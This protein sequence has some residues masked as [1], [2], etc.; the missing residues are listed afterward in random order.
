MTHEEMNKECSRCWTEKPLTEFTPQPSGKYGRHSYCRECMR[1][2]RNRWNQTEKGKASIKKY[3]T[4]RKDA[5]LVEL[6]ASKV[7]KGCIDC[8]YNEDPIFLNYVHRAGTENLFQIRYDSYMRSPET[9]EA[10]M[11]KC[12]VRCVFCH[13]EHLRERR[14][15]LNFA[16][17]HIERK[18][19]EFAEWLD[20][21]KLERGC[22]DCGFKRT[23]SALEFDHLPE[24]EKSFSVNRSAFQ[25]PRWVVEEE[26]AKCEVVCSGCHRRRTMRRKGGE[27]GN[28]VG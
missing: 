14:Q 26:M 3:T 4:R 12:D 11:A 13:G 9:V 18:Y 16:K 10:E 25:R 5:W 28:A 24:H 23:A 1:A 21:I 20:S 19:V 2:Y 6:N 22:K 8:G 17:P 7:A 15:P 27:A